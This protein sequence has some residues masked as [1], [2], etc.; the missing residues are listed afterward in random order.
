MKK[1]FIFGLLVAGGAAAY[2]LVKKL[3]EKVKEDVE[4]V[5]FL[6]VDEDD[7][8]YSNDVLEISG[9]YP[10][11]SKKFINK[12]YAQNDKLNEDYPA[13]TLVEIKHFASFG[14]DS[15]VNHFVRLMSSNGH[16]VVTSED[17]KDVVLTKK[18]YSEHGK[19]ISEIFNVANQVNNLGGLYTG[20]EISE[21]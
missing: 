6:E 10:F 4:N 17:G 1:S 8:E 15:D 19:L 14:D 12:V 7:S 11:L 5:K 2:Y 16:E 20:Y 13:E 9:I 3:E 21:Q 18:F